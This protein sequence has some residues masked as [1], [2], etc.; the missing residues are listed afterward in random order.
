MNTSLQRRDF[1]KR[2]SEFPFLLR[3]GKHS[4]HIDLCIKKA[5]I[6]QEMWN[7]LAVFQR[8]LP[9]TK[10]QTHEVTRTFKRKVLPY[11]TNQRRKLPAEPF[12]YYDL[13][14]QIATGSAFF[15][16]YSKSPKIQF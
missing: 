9:G 12:T 11:L 7:L 1:L 6:D 14:L 4:T 13:L 8:L 10:M 15:S 3:K 16:R 2:I 5:N